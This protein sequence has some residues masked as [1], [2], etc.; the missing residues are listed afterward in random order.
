MNGFLFAMLE[1]VIALEN[2]LVLSLTLFSW[3][4]RIER[5]GLT[6]EVA[7]VSVRAQM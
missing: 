5:G 3:A 6:T 1:Y 7:V 4:L 2:Y